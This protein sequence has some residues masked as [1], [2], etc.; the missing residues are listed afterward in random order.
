MQQNITK[1]TV[2]SDRF[3]IDSLENEGD[4]GQ[5]YKA[6]D[7]KTN[8]FVAVRIV[9]LSILR[10]DEVEH[11]KARMQQ[12]SALVH[13]NVR[14][15]FGMGVKDE[16]L[17]IAAEWIEGQN[18]QTLLKKR[19]DA[20]K[21]FSFKGAYN[22]IGHVCNALTYTHENGCYHGALNPRSIMVN[23]AGRVKVHDWA[24]STIRINKADYRGRE[25]VEAAYWSPEALKAPRTVSTRSDI[26]SL[27][28]LFYSLITGRAPQRPLIAPSKLGFSSDVDSVVAR[29]M[30]ADPKQRFKSAA[31]V[32]QAIKQLASSQQVAAEPP[33][34]VDDDLGIDIDIDLDAMNAPEA[35]PAAPQ[36]APAGGM[37]SAPDLPPPP[38]K[39]GGSGSNER[40]STI[41]M[42]AILANSVQNEAAR[43]MVQKDKFDHG[44]FNDRELIQMI[45]LGDVLGN[46]RLTNMD[47]GERK[48]VRSWGDF[49]DYLERYRIKKQQQ[50]EQAALEKT[51]KAETRGM[52]F[53]LVIALS[54][55]GVIGLAV[56]GYFLSRKLRAEKQLG[57]EEMVDAFDSGEIQ[58]KMGSMD[59]KT[60]GKRHGKGRRR[61]SSGGGGGGKGE[62]VDGM[63]YEE[64]MNMGV[65]LGALN[66]T[67][68]KKLTAE[69]INAIMSRN[70][71]KFIPCIA[72]ES[73]KRVDM[74]IAVAGNGSVI[75]VSVQQGSGKMKSCVASKVRSIKF[76]SSNQPRTATSWYFELY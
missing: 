53:K 4:M 6:H 66:S 55:L 30:S 24:L 52:L 1:G 13:R 50:D 43:W 48:K 8:K 61:G 70:V 58:I 26:F 39:G 60:A 9:P 17:F 72:G 27:G 68:G 3:V 33:G 32:K 15:T 54:V 11:V 69:D 71:R 42:G 76:P 40:A 35:A 38:N 59:A 14:A 31:D 51:E 49:D 16:F 57:P 21:R 28:A 12:A 75:G 45:L 7:T 37:M 44:P 56:G 36:T 25:K 46:H 64:A 10:P 62:F 63:S 41:D 22:I 74:N 5:V 20:D 65:S 73:V 47:T 23:N 29:C 34:A 19:T 18:L 67:G 2:L